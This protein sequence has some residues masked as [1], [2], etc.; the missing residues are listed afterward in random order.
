MLTYSHWG[1]RL[2]ILEVQKLAYFLQEAGEPL[3]LKFQA[4]QYGPYA[5]NLHHVLQRIEGH[6]IRG[7]GDRAAPS[8]IRLLPKVS[9]EARAFLTDK[10]EAEGHLER[11]RQLIEGFETPYGMELLAT[12]HWVVSHDKPKS[13]DPDEITAKVRSW[14]KRKETLLKPQHIRKALTRLEQQH[15]LPV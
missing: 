9:E 4:N 5:E 1:Y 7:Y 13:S 11:V 14:N 10:P 2:G 8:E 12:V 15:W 3:K 6:Y